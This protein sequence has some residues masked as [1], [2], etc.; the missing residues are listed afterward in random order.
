MDHY[1]EQRRRVALVGDAGA[2]PEHA[3]FLRYH[4][5]LEITSVSVD[6]AT[7]ELD[8]GYAAVCLQHI[9]PDEI[10]AVRIRLARSQP[11]LP[12][13]DT[14]DDGAAVVVVA[15]LINA[16]RRARALLAGIRVLVIDADAAPGIGALLTAAGARDLS[17]AGSRTADAVLD[18][19]PVRYDALID[20]SI[21]ADPRGITLTFE[22]GATG[23]QQLHPLLALPG[24]LSI[25]VRRRVGID[26]TDRFAAAHALARLAPPGDLLPDAGDP[27]ITATIYDAAA[28][29][30]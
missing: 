5:G 9:R 3:E 27:R 2:A 8:S 14:G 25:A 26:V 16:V 29:L 23:P 11:D 13:L 18:D 30:R 22:P 10:D 24:L 21:G 17:F 20:L 1:I 28:G 15:A 6:E 12:V 7:A 19:L 4:S